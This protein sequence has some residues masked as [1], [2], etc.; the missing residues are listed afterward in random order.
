MGEIYHEAFDYVLYC[1]YFAVGLIIT[2]RSL[3]AAVRR[4]R[5][6]M[7]EHVRAIVTSECCSQRSVHVPFVYAD[8]TG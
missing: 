5:A 2:M 1:R 4:G 8:A 7:G 6:T 3:P